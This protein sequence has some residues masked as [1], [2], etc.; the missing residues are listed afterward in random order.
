MPPPITERWQAFK[1]LRRSFQRLPVHLSGRKDA[2]AGSE[3]V[4]GPVFESANYEFNGL[5]AI[6]ASNAGLRAYS[7]FVGAVPTIAAIAHKE[8]D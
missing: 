2:V 4:L 6:S 3:P 1:V 8:A 5:A 7:P